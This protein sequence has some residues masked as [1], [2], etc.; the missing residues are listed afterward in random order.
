MLLI[1]TA[2]I[3]VTLES[4]YALAYTAVQEPCRRH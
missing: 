3:A 1:S 2:D 4:F